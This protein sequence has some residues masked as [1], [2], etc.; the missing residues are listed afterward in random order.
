MWGQGGPVPGPGLHGAGQVLH[1]CKEVGAGQMKD[2]RV[3]D[4]VRLLSPCC[5]LQPLGAS[6]ASTLV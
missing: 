2:G 3:G 6:L 1:E 5:T 4:S